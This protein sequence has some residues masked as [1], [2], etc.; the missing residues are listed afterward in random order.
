MFSSK[1]V[2]GRVVSMAHALHP[3]FPRRRRQ[4]LNPTP[5]LGR[6]PYLDAT[7]ASASSLQALALHCIRL[8]IGPEFAFREVYWGKGD[9]TDRALR[10][11]RLDRVSENGHLILSHWCSF[12]KSLVVIEGG[13]LRYAG[14]GNA[15][16]M[17]NLQTTRLQ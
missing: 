3:L 16:N 4:T 13:L 5:Y 12:S 6:C 2:L 17:E 15:R 9:G 14:N 1:N 10:P 7:D 8:Q 11:P